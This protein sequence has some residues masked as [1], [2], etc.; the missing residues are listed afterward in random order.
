MKTE[1]MVVRCDRC[2]KEENEY[3][4]NH[5]CLKGNHIYLDMDVCSE[6][7]K[8]LKGVLKRKEDI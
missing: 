1:C 8:E 6:C 2:G 5:I 7:T 4:I 3:F